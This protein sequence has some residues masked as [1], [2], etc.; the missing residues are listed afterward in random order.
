[1]VLSKKA[2][3]VVAVTMMSSFTAMSQSSQ[4]D[5]KKFYT[6]SEVTLSE[7]KEDDFNQMVPETVYR[8]T[9]ENSYQVL[10]SPSPIDQAG[11]VVR[12][13]RDIV[14][15]GED[16]YKLVIKGKPVVA[17]TYAPVSVVPKIN[18]EP[19]DPMDL[20]NMSM[21][22]ARSFE[23]V[24]KNLYGIKVVQFKYTVI[25]TY[26]GTYDGKGAYISG[27]QIV[28]AS[29]NALFGFDFSAN[30][31]VGGI[32]NLGTRVNP[33]ASAILLMDY[34]VSNVFQSNS[35]VDNIFITGKGVVRKV[36]DNTL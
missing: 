26:G 15:L 25:F 6:I 11:Q 5:E 23:L 2:V 4:Y 7:I 13:A 33:V 19:V 14:A 28:P 12:I 36:K 3:L 20:E 27:A 1:M 10:P 17:T 30:M 24:Y 9:I 16:I 35:K 22:K 32:S 29:I 34:T 21:P 8:K 18:K 31:K